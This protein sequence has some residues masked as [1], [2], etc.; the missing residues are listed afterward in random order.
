[1]TP[2]VYTFRVVPPDADEAALDELIRLWRRSW[3][4]NGWEPVVLTPDDLGEELESYTSAVSRLPSIN[5]PVRENACYQ[6]WLAVARQGG[7]WM[8]DIDL[9]NYG[10]SP[11]HPECEEVM[12]NAKPNQI[13]CCDMHVPCLVYGSEEAFRDTA[14]RFTLLG[15]FGAA[16]GQTLR[17]VEMRGQPHTSDMIILEGMGSDEY[18]QADL[19]REFQEDGWKEAKL[20]H[21]SC[22]RM[23]GFKPKGRWIPVIEKNRTK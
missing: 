8:C 20:V 3:R 10:F 15:R 16:S 19:V 6:R 14:N 22:G 21:Y 12:R 1:M 5:H 9:F 13:T 4:R 7:G 2:K 18:T 23:R 17:T 11:G